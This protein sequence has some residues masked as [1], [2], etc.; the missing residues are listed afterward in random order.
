M[1]SSREIMVG[2]MNPLGLH[3]K[4]GTGHHYGP[5]PWVGDQKR[6]EW[7]PIYYHKADAEGIGFDRTATG[8]NAIAQYQPA[9]QKQW[10]NLNDCDEKY[11]LWFHHVSWTHKLKSGRT[12]W[13]ELCYRYYKGAEKVAKM[14]QQWNALA[15]FVDKE[16]F[17]H[18]QQLLHIQ[19][20]EAVWWRNAC[21]LYF[22]E[23]SKLP[24]PAE[25]QQPDKTL[26]YYKKLQFPFAPGN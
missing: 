14:Q 5:A 9:A 4:M 8:S 20:D 24:I 2:Y 17:S 7:N 13:N 16:R 1:L 10:N 22:Q 23:F 26:E 19:H 12:L 18:V 25:Y 6:P 11:L 3:H 15:P 21:L